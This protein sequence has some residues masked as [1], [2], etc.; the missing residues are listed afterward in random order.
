LLVV[1][2]MARPRL[3]TRQAVAMH[4]LVHA[5]E[6]VGHAELDVNNALRIFAAQGADAA[7]GLG[8]AG[9]NPR[10]ESS[11]LFKT[12]FGLRSPAP[13]RRQGRQ[14]AIA[15]G[16]NPSLDKAPAA[17]GVSLNRQ[18]LLAPQRQPHDTITISLLSIALATDA[19][20][21]LRQVVLMMRSHIHVKPPS[22]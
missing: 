14:S 19:S 21:E 2:A 6:A 3:Q 5:V 12:E 22:R 11:L 9:L 7:V 18:R 4:D 17:L 1:L 20:F 13:P 10:D 8:G 16:V 15:I